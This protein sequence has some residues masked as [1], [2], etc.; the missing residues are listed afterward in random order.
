MALTGG[1]E[2]FNEADNPKAETALHAFVGTVKA[3]TSQRDEALIDRRYPTCAD[4]SF[5]DSFQ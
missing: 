3:A 1:D 4:V 2:L 5:T